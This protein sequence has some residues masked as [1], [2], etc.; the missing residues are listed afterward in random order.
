M[1]GSLTR[2]E[3]ERELMRIKFK[4]TREEREV[5]IRTRRQE[6]TFMVELLALLDDALNDVGDC[7]AR[8]YANNLCANHTFPIFSI[9][10]DREFVESL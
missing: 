7:R 4:R 2:S 8:A 1:I 5:R 9:N 10:I 6:N 3:L